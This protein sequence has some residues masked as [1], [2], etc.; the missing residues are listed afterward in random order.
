MNTL[1]VPLFSPNRIFGTVLLVN[2]K[3]ALLAGSVLVSDAG[4]TVPAELNSRDEM[5]CDDEQSRVHVSSDEPAV[6]TTT[7]DS[8]GNNDRVYL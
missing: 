4:M 5:I 1:F 2:S 7:T 6:T 8:D 3:Y